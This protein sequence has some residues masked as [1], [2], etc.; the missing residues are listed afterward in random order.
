[1][2]VDVLLLC[3]IGTST[4][5]LLVHQK[6]LGVCCKPLCCKPFMR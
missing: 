6:Q 3:A 5:L 1:M 2:N 4:V